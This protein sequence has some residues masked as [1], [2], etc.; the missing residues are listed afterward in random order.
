MTHALPLIFTLAQ[1]NPLEHVLD[2]P[3]L[4]VHG[5][6]LLSNNIITLVISAVAMLIIFPLITRAYVRGEHVPTGTRNFFEAILFYIREEMAR[7]VLGD[8]TDR[9]IPFLWTLFFFILFNNLLGLIPLDVLTG[10]FMGP[11]H[12]HPIGGAATANIWV[13]AALAVIAFVVWQVNGI[14]A[15][16]LGTYLK[17]FLGGAPIWLA[18]LMIP[19]EFIGMLIKPFALAI[20]LFANMFA[21]HMVLAVLLM[22]T[23]TAF[24]AGA[25]LG[26]TVSI[27]VVLASVAMMCLE[28]FVAFLQTYI[29]VF[30]TAMFIAQL[31]VHE[32]AHRKGEGGSHDESHSGLGTG[33]LT[34]FSELPDAPRQ[35]AMHMAG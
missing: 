16:G 15:N 7:P 34:D 32:H 23:A 18:P 12:L 4:T 35:A 13:T 9:Y 2:K 30:L 19:L 1:A 24:G 33:D 28:L 6:W 27:V 29:F 14:R 25:A 20:R 31:V 21:G 11:L 5:W 8:Q 17:H 3:V 10:W 26:W 22:F